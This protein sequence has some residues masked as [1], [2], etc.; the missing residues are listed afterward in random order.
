LLVRNVQ[1]FEHRRLGSPL[2]KR[3][4]GAFLL[5]GDKILFIPSI[6]YLPLFILMQHER[7]FYGGN[8]FI[9]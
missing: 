6:L 5:L 8:I 4:L 1:V 3:M 9:T 2:M 7:E